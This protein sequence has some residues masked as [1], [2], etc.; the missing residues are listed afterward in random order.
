MR[1]KTIEVANKKIVIEEKRIK[2][3]KELAKELNISFD[4]ILKT[5]LEG[6]TTIDVV[7]LFVNEL[8]DKITIIFPQ[9]TK[10]DIEE[11]YVSEI[12][13][14]IEGFIDVNFSVLKKVFIKATSMM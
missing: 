13:N 1:T 10:E 4:N 9:L 7:D 3:L 8:E 2:E 14:L 6:K 12:E 11:A 5:D